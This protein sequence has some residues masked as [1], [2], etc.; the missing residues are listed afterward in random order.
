MD[1]AMV[2]RFYET[3]YGGVNLSGL[4]T[5]GSATDVTGYRHRVGWV[6]LLR[7]L[8]CHKYI[9]SNSP[10]QHVRRVLR[11]LGL[12][13]VIWSGILCPDTVGGL[14]KASPH[15]YKRVADAHPASDGWHVTLLDDSR[16]NTEVAS[17][18]CQFDTV[19][20]GQLDEEHKP[21]DLSTALAR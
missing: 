21:V 17:T 6:R 19:L 5:T 16:P 14:T 10:A 18:S 12:A 20:V 3:V 1:S 15:F 7:D 13:D 8:P 2:Q 11:A 4:Y 9:A